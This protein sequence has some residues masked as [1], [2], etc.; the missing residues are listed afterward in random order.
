MGD[1]LGNLMGG[2]ET[3]MRFDATAVLQGGST[4]VNLGGWR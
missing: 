3:E 4:P 1:V 2:V